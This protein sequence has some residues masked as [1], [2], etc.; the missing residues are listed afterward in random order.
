SV[1]GPRPPDVRH[2]VAAAVVDH[3]VD[4]AVEPGHVQRDLRPGHVVRQVLFDGVARL[5][6]VQPGDVDA[7]VDPQADRAV[8]PHQVQ[9]ADRLG[10]A[11][12][13]VEGDD[14]P[15][16]FQHPQ[17]AAADVAPGLVHGHV[18]DAHGVV[19]QA[20]VDGAFRFDQEDAGERLVGQGVGHLDLQNV[21][22]LQAV[23]RQRGPAYQLDVEDVGR[24]DDVLR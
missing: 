12:R 16:L 10:Q 1:P 23:R 17:Q 19:G 20:E 24:F 3:V 7:A 14:R 5:P 13:L 22:R 21:P 4:L 18:D 8:N 9:A 11:A 15:R 2:A 6:Q